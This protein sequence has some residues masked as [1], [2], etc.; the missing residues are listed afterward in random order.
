MDVYARKMDEL[1][2]VVLPRELR[3]ELSLNTG[4]TLAMKCDGSSITLKKKSRTCLL[5]GSGEDIIELSNR[6]MVCA[7][8]AKEIALFA[9]E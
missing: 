2:R 5:C 3:N 8:C 7:N 9:E 1:G 4:D 6:S